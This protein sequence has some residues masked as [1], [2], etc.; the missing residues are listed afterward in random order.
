VR[1]RILVAIAGAALGLSGAAPAALAD[2][3]EGNSAAAHRCNHEGYKSLVGSGGQ[4]FRNTG[5]CV[6]FAA[7]G[8]KFASGIVIPKGSTATFSNVSFNACNSLTYGYQLNPGTNTDV[9]SKPPGCFSEGEP[10]VT[11]GPFATAELVR[12]YL[13]DNTCGFTFFSDGNHAGVTGENPYSVRISD[14]GGF[15]E[16]PP[17]VSRPPSPPA[18]LELTLTIS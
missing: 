13:T 8:G 14:A 16:G 1:K 9:A 4:T 18:N 15:C 2:E 11:I 5:E 12:V 7:H 17:S 10:N 6:S 3:A